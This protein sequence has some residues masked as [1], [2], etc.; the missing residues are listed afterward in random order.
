VEAA[1]TCRLRVNIYRFPGWIVRVDG[2]AVPI[3]DLPKQQ[4][5]IFLDV[6][7][8]SHD[9]QVVFERTWPRRLGDGLTLAGLAAL[10]LVG[11]WPRKERASNL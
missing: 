5:V 3:L 7:P 9:V 1:A 6:A 11:L 8:G 2:A 10:A 4:R